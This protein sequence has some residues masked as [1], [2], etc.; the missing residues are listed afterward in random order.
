MSETSTPSAP[1][2]ASTAPATSAP[3]AAPPTP[4]PAVARDPKATQAA[5][6]R[7]IQARKQQEVQAKRAEQLKPLE[8]VQALVKQGKHA[9]AFRKLAGGDLPEV[10]RS[11]TEQMLGTQDEQKALEALPKSVREKLA[12]VDAL[13][14]QLAELQPVAERVKS[15]E[16]GSQKA[17]AT[18]E[19]HQR[20]TMAKAVWDA[21]FAE[22]K[23]DPDADVVMRHEKAED[24]VQE[25]W[26]RHLEKARQSPEWA[27]LTPEER[28]QRAGAMVVDAARE[29]QAEWTET[30]N[31][32]LQAR[33]LRDK[34]GRWAPQQRA[35]AP[36]APAEPAPKSTPTA[37][38]PKTGT[39]G[40]LGEPTGTDFRKL[41]YE[42]RVALLRKEERQGLLR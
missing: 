35:S 31:R 38:V 3:A 32:V 34:N 26:V 25:R 41:S 5:L 6:Q 9:D 15:I 13:K 4:P 18:L 1:A 7:V 2:A 42:E 23:N 39:P 30:H 8:E 29:I 24:L 28:Q 10:Y 12:E 14:A 22:A 37:S 19:E 40:S 33:S 11:L 16:E 20:A 17:R 27:K 21:S 36:Q